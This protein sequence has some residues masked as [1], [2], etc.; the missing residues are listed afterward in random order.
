MP[1]T[2]IVLSNFRD[3]ACSLSLV[4]LPSFYR[5]FGAGARPDHPITGQSQIARPCPF[6]R[7]A[8]AVANRSLWFYLSG[9]LNC[10]G[11]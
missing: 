8:A 3:M 1:T 10:V 2:A 7:Y 4:P 5:W 9:F 11:E 6:S